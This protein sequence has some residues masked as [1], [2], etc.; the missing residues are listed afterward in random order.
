[1]EDDG[2]NRL[3]AVVVLR[4]MIFAQKPDLARM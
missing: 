4:F 3:G 2:G 1:V